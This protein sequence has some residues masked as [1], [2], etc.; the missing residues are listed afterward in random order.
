MA[1]WRL[2][3]LDDFADVRG[4][5][6]LPKGYKLQSEPTAHP[7][8]TVTDFTDDGT[9][10]ARGV[11][12]ISDQVFEEIKRYTISSKDLYLSIAGTIGKTGCV[13]PE[14]EGANLTENACKLVLRAGI[15]RNFL[16]YFTKTDEFLQQARDQT[17]IAAQPKL[18][19]ERLKSI[20]VPVPDSLPEQQRIVAILDEAFAGIA[21]A[22]ANAEKNL[23]NARELFES[24]LEAKFSRNGAGWVR[25]PLA[26]ICDIKHGFPFKSEF[27]RDRGEYVLLTPGN[28]YES[29]GYRDRG[30]KQKYYDGEIPDGFVLQGGDLLV[31][32]TEQA[33]GLLG[34]PILVPQ[35]KLFLHNQRL[36]LVVAK[37]N[38]P[39]TNEFFFHVFN[40]RP[41]RCAIHNGASGVKVRHTS[42]GKIGEVIVA[43][44]ASVPEQRAIVNNLGGLVDATRRLES[45]YRQKLNALDD[46]KK[47]L[48]HQAFTGQ[49]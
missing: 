3:Q 23:R 35:S 11:R 6:R 12:Y 10:D 15:D 30:A 20:R 40:T 5:K 44:P 19:L 17:R 41:V 26:D 28:F 4:G 42:P 45:I 29:G 36:G 32:M 33:A 13:P 37:P 31:A 27:F 34:S 49:L 47:S 22:K 24:Q 16:Y 21:T 9:I 25:K 8:I 2:K 43:F 48:L 7:Y 1:A 46:F 14:L 18:A 38:V 39:W